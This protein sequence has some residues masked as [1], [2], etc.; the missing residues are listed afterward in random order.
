[1]R[2]LPIIFSAEMVKAIV[3]NR[4]TMTRRIK[5]KCEVG[6]LLWIRE[7]WGEAIFTNGVARYA[8]NEVIFPSEKSSFP[9]KKIIYKADGKKA[10]AKKWKPSIHM[11]KKYARIWLEIIDI[12]IEKLQ[13]IDAFD[14]IK[15]GIKG[16]KRDIETILFLGLIPSIIKRFRNLWDSI[17]EKRGYGWDTN[18]EVKVIE[19]KIK[20]V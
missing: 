3:E 12:R 19:F 16:Q 13:D 4:K 10:E 15:E 1:M 11:P 5:F 9:E 7:T 6:D 8:R 14:C 18:P 2:E 20:E 17:N